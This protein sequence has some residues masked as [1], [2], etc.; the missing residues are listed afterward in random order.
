MGI[1][2]KQTNVNLKSVY[3]LFSQDL[4]DALRPIA[5]FII[6]DYIWTRVK[7]DLKKRLL[8]VERPGT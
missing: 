2:D 3:R 5:M 8:I 6:L 1:F 4:P 7:K